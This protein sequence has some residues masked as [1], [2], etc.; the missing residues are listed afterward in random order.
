MYGTFSSILVQARVT[1]CPSSRSKCFLL[2]YFLSCLEL[3]PRSGILSFLF[4]FI[5]LFFWWEWLLLLHRAMDHYM[6]IGSDKVSWLFLNCEKLLFS[7][8]ISFRIKE[9]FVPMCHFSSDLQI[10]IKCVHG[11]LRN[12]PC[13]CFHFS[14]VIGSCGC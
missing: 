2:H 3:F 5:N 13:C 1:S 6:D 10:F 9:S 11:D 7:I 12:R 8:K 14:C 4:L